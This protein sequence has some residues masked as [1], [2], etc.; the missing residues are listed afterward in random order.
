VKATIKICCKNY[1]GESWFGHMDGQIK[2][3][4]NQP[5]DMDKET[6]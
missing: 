5:V 3:I 1:T 2:I 6:K 4:V